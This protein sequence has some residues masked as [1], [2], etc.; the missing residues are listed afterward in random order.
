MRNYTCDLYQIFGAC[1]LPA[2]KGAKSAIY[3]CL[4]HGIAPFDRFWRSVRVSCRPP[5]CSVDRPWRIHLEE[6]LHSNKDKR[7]QRTLQ[8]SWS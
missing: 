2:A 6:Y 7:S 3:H 1:C 4:V 8:L 5:L